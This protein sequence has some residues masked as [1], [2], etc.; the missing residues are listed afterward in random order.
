M[1]PF[2]VDPLTLRKHLK[3]KFFLRCFQGGSKGN[4]GKKSVKNESIVVFVTSNFYYPTPMFAALMQKR[5]MFFLS[6][7]CFEI[8]R[9]AVP[10][11]FF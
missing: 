1:F 8:Q 6:F 9:N 10:F 4:I 11:I 5:V 2:G 3:T 7:S